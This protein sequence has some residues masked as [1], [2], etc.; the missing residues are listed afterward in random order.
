[1]KLFYAPASSYSQ[2]VLIAFY[3]KGITFTPIEVNLFHP[4]TRTQYITINPFAK[5]PSLETDDGQILFEACI[6]I[7]YL[8]LYYQNGFCL[9]PQNPKLALETRRLERIVDVYIN[10]GRQILFNDIQQPI[11]K[12]GGK[13]VVKARQLLETACAYLDKQLQHR[14]WL[15]GEEFSLADCAAAP[16]LIYLRMNYSYGHL[17]RLTDYVKRLE[18]RPSVARVQREGQNQMNRMLAALQPR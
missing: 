6:I 15:A 7:E 13:E 8:D 18:A 1:M 11:E 16:T 12:Q 4:K 14:T 5:L 9:L 3:E 10:T 2:R 17:L